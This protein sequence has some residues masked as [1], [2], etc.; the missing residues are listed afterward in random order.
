MLFQTSTPKKQALTPLPR[1][2]TP[3]KYYSLIKKKIKE[4]NN[5]QQMINEKSYQN[6]QMPIIKL[7]LLLYRPKPEYYPRKN[8][9]QTWD[10]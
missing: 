6:Y 7:D 9:Q 8:I 4:N 3:N 2:S 1:S 5:R 10:I